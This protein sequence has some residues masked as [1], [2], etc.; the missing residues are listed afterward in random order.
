MFLPRIIPVL[1]VSNNCLVKTTR[2][3]NPVYIGDPVNA[4]NIFNDFYADELII[5]DIDATGKNTCFSF[6]LMQRIAT[7]AKMPL[8]FGGGFNNISDIKKALQLGAEKIVIGTSWFQ[9]PD[10]INQAAKEVGSSAISVCVDVVRKNDGYQVKYL[11][12]KKPTA[13]GLLETVG[14]IEAAGGGEIVIQ[15]IDNDGKMNGYDL[16]LI[17]EVADKV[18]IPI[19]ALG[20]A[21]SVNDITTVLKKCCASAAAGSM[22]VFYNHQKG[23]LI[24][25]P[26]INL[27]LL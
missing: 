19:V 26:K 23:V 13:I 12:G 18:T 2:F 14:Q 15:S 9:N 5:L 16:Q 20:G 17:Q 7:V 10:L 24:N 21:G 25:Y 1:L 27:N 6:E 4:V 11:N 8:A 3:T 22:F